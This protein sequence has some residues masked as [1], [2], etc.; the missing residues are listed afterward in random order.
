MSDPVKRPAPSPCGSC[1][2]RQDV[3][4]GV[5]ADEEYAKLPEY[6]G[7]LWSQPP[8][9]FCCHQQDGRVCA[10][11]AGVHD[12]DENLGLRLAV[13]ADLMSVEEAEAT[14]D[15]ESPV[16]LFESGAAAAEH[17]LA[18]VEKPGPLAGRLIVKLRQRQERG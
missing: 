8:S 4:S 18:E 10:G 1:P 11:W 5:W 3:P 15:Y 16:P 17:G 13:H 9:V 14:L 2:Y 12:M 6:D 7:P